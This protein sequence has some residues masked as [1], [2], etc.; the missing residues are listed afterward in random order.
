MDRYPRRPRAPFTGL[1]LWDY[2]WWGYLIFFRLWL[3]CQI[4]TGIGAFIYW[5][6][7]RDVS[8]FFFRNY[9]T[10]WTVYLAPLLPDQLW[11]MP[12]WY[13]RSEW[14]VIGLILALRGVEL[15][16]RVPLFQNI[17]P[18]VFGAF[19]RRPEAS[20]PFRSGG[21][22]VTQDDAYSYDPARFAA[23]ARK[24]PERD[25]SRPWP[26][27]I[28]SRQDQQAGQAHGDESGHDETRDAKTAKAERLLRD[29]RTSPH[30]REATQRLLDR[31]KNKR[32]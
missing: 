12:M 18:S 7:P 21:Q 24:P 31:R 32:S 29:P 30:V 8:E 26:L 1:N 23:G 11:L 10:L 5:W 22:R 14:P 9:I 25:S 28:E 4:V 6:L 20:R 2:V 17:L 16:R 13:E 15:L 27:R 3:L 19:V